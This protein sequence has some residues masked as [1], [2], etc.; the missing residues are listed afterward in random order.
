MYSVAKQTM[1]NRHVCYLVSTLLLLS[2]FSPSSFGENLDVEHAASDTKKSLP[3]SSARCKTSNDLDQQTTLNPAQAS[4]SGVNIYADEVNYLPGSN[5]M[6]NGQVEMLYGR[7]HAQSDSASI[8]QASQRAQLDGDILVS[9]PDLILKGDT[10]KMNLSSDKISITNATFSNPKTLINGEASKLSQPNKDTIIIRD[11][12]FTACPPENRS[13][14]FSSRKI[15]LNRELGFGQANDTRFLIKD[16][17]VMYIP[18]FSFPIDDRRKSGFLY[19]T[20]GSSNTERGVFL[21]TPYYFNIAPNLDSTLTPSYIHG[22][23]LH[24]EIETRYKSRISYS[25][26]KVGFIDR[27]KNYDDKLLN[28]GFASQDS[29]W[30]LNFEQN[31]SPFANGWH[32]KIAYSAVSDNDYLSDLNQG[33]NIDKKDYLDR[34]AQF[35]FSDED[36]RISV[37]LQQY[38]S[39]DDGITASQVAY[40]RL[41]EIDFEFTDSYKHFQLDWQ[42]QYVYFYRNRSDLIGLERSFGSRVRHQP[43]VSLP[44]SK[45]WGFVKP[46]FTLDHTDYFLQDYTPVDNHL[47]RSIPIYELDS[48]LYFDKTSFLGSK[49]LRHSLEPRL[50]YVYSKNQSQNNVPNFDST[51]P[52]FHYN[53]LFRANRFTGGDRIS[54]NNRLTLGLSSRWTDLDSGQEKVRVSIGQIYHYDNREVGINNVG[55]SE[56]SDSLLASEVM[57][58]P[59]NGLEFRLTGLWDAREK[60]TH[61]GNMSVYAHT[62]DYSSVVNLS[63]RYIRNE[64][65]QSDSSFITPIYQDISLIGRWRYDLDN[66]RTIGTLAGVE[67]SGCCWRMQFLTQSYADSD[68]EIINGFLFRFQLN[69]VG[70]FGQS[71]SNMDKQIRGYRARE[72]QFN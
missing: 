62:K 52:S 68:S 2:L 64:L 17:P 72:E 10:A 55:V 32:G 4:E 5:L 33:L 28:S 49:N 56:R 57:L 24:S 20:I 37:L 7:Y 69:G 34:R 36:W 30:G 38:E 23:G 53:T 65:E 61:E 25:N 39:I 14:A 41:P 60:Q 50:Y 51:L 21:S 42:S 63:H 16:I 40:Q 71:T 35:H 12:L 6:L 9:S 67:Y 18:W 19:P 27:D 66:N 29:R 45:T 31:I 44:F 11:G 54:D 46:S 58:N 15:T 22:R 8:D 70:N 47:S 13:W 1:K 59:F 26:L 3:L 43:K 48:G